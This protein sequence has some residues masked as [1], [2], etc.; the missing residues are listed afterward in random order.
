[1]IPLHRIPVERE[2]E[3]TYWETLRDFPIFTNDRLYF[4]NLNNTTTFTYRTLDNVLTNLTVNDFTI[5]F[6]Y[7]E[8]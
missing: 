3:R 4:T 8:L 7:N 6:N 5:E 2:I 1:M